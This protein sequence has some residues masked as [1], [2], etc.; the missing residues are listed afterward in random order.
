MGANVPITSFAGGEI[1]KE[2]LARVDLDLYQT[3]G[4]IFENCWPTMRG[5]LMRVPGTEYIGAVSDVRTKL[6]PFAFNVDQTRVL[7]IGDETMKFVD[8]D[9]YVSLTGGT[10]TVAN[11]LDNTST[12][13]SSISGTSTLIFTCT[14]GGQAKAYWGITGGQSGVQTTFSF[15]VQRRP[16][17]FSVGTTTGLEDILSEITLEP[18]FHVITILPTANTYYLRMRLDEEGK[19]YCLNMA[20]EAAGVLELP[21]PWPIA[22]LDS[23]RMRQSNDVI[24]FYHPDY[25]TRVLERRGDTSWSLRLFR[26]EDGPFDTLNQTTTTLTPSAT[27]GSVN[28]T[29]SKAIFSASSVGQL[30]ELTHQGQTETLNA[31]AV[32][33]AS[34]PIRV[35]GIDSNRQFTLQIAG[36]FV[37]TVKLQRSFG[38]TVDWIDYT[39]YSAVTTVIVDDTLDNQIIYYRVICSAYTSGTIQCTLTYGN[40]ET[41]GRCEIVAYTNT[42]TVVAEVYES[43]GSTNATTRWSEGSWSTVNGWPVAGVI[44]DSRHWLINEDNRLF[45]SASD[46]YE[47]FLIDS[48]VSAGIS[49]TIGVGETNVP[50]WIDIASRLVVGTHGGELEVGSNNLDETITYLNLKARVV[51]DEGSANTQAARA[52]KR[53]AFIDMSRT[54]LLQAYQ[55]SDTGSTEIDDLC[56]LHEKIAGDNITQG[57]GDGFVELAYQKRPE[58][59]IWIVR[60]DG[61]LCVQLYV[62]REGIYAWARIIG[63]ESASGDAGLFRSVC[64]IPGAPEDRVHV[65]VERVID[66]NTVYYHERFALNRFPIETDADGNKSA[67]QAWRLQCALATDGVATTTFSNLDHL[68]GETVRIWADGKDVGTK[69]VTAGVVTLDDEAEYVIIG[70]EAEGRWKSSKMSYGARKGTGLTMEKQIGRLGV[71]THE[72][73]IG[74]VLWGRSF[75]LSTDMISN[76]LYDDIP[77]DQPAFLVESE[78]NVPFEGATEVDPRIYLKMVGA[79]PVTVLAI[80]PNVELEEQ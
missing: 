8:D 71:V 5:S 44:E 24:Y 66:G 7:E 56:R 39:S 32:D 33:Q 12:G 1:G 17:K 37:G 23:L 62:P 76:E 2:A 72:T 67:P 64:V 52:G 42:T 58:K 26:P 77:M 54:R 78:E 57:S 22:E 55:D 49:R 14:A 70:L 60:S 65:I 48:D 41:T 4:E 46:D 19:A 18:G 10:A 20:R 61:Q 34:D 69:V 75:D 3:T 38:N 43:F 45:V 47:S 35:I 68:E 27:S 21:T 9:A 28:I 6:R 53:V 13:G 36:T 74:A 59:R 16:V 73:P 30:L 63:A 80:V 51:G 79:A 15:E 40:G 11:P 25:R 50:R 29:A 31:T